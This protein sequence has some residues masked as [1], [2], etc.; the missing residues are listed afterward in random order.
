MRG[1]FDYGEISRALYSLGFQIDTFLNAESVQEVY[2]SDRDD[3]LRAFENVN[4]L[5]ALYTGGFDY[6]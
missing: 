2:F 3:D 6:E 1:G 5:S 4:L